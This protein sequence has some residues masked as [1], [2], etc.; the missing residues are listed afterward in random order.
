MLGKSLIK[1]PKFRR[2]FAYKRG[3]NNYYNYLLKSNRETI[4]INSPSG[5][6]VV[7]AIYSYGLTTDRYIKFGFGQQKRLEKKIENIKRKFIEF[8]KEE[9]ILKYSKK[10]E[11][12]DNSD[13]LTISLEGEK[14]NDSDLLSLLAQHNIAWFAV[15]EGILKK[16]TG[17]RYVVPVV[18]VMQPHKPLHNVKDFVVVLDN[19]Q[20]HGNIGTIIRTASAFNISSVAV[21][22]QDTDLFYRKAIDASRGKV[23]STN[24]IRFDSDVA[25]V[26]KLQQQGFQVVATSPHASTVQSLTQLRKQPIAVV[27]G[28][29]TE[30]SRQEILE[31]ADHVIQIP[32]SGDVES[33]NVAVAAGISLYELKI[34]MVLTMLTEK[35]KETLGR[36]ISVALQLIQQAL[37]HQLQHVTH[38]SSK[39]LIILMVCKCDEKMSYQQ[40]AKDMG[41]V[42]SELEEFLAPLI[43][44]QLIEADG[45]TI[46]LAY[47]GEEFLARIWTVVERSEQE[48]LAGFSAEEKTLFADFLSRLHSN[49]KDIVAKGTL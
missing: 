25:C 41:L 36:N 49:C 24:I 8:N 33:L 37:D 34:K 46:V 22:G 6:R 40:I 13:I 42:E 45:K 5:E 47:K 1:S 3:L 18:G 23:F 31:K 29:E 20:D 26:E 30:G 27:L 11:S 9:F 21:T 43:E 2:V 7:R 38:F 32:M 14:L 15:S 39:Q 48:T 28:N 19:L 10:V 12:K 44:D 35:I 17:T 4:V 16:V